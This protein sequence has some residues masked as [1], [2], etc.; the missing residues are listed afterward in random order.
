[1][2][3]KGTPMV[4][5]RIVTGE[6]Q[7][8]KLSRGETVYIPLK[9]RTHSIPESHTAFVVG[10]CSTIIALDAQSLIGR[11]QNHQR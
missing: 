5:D 1:M 3:R 10:S 9:V 8:G 6:R 7:Q 11:N 4:A 2:T